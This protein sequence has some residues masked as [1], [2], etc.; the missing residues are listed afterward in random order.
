MFNLRPLIFTLLLTVLFAGWLLL[1]RDSPATASAT[2]KSL[3]AQDQALMEQMERYRARLLHDHDIDYHILTMRQGANLSLQA[4]IAFKR[5]N[6]G[7]TSREG[8]GVLLLLD[9]YSNS[10]VMEISPGLDTVFMDDFV[11]YI[12]QQMPPFL[13]EGQTEQGIFDATE[14]IVLRAKNAK[15]QLDFERE[16]WALSRSEP[17][18]SALAN[19][20]MRNR[21]P[22]IR[23][24][25]SERRTTKLPEIVLARYLRAMVSGYRYPIIEYYSVT[26][27]EVLYSWNESRRQLRQLAATLRQLEPGPYGLAVIGQ[28]DSGPYSQLTALR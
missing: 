9:E 5:L 16:P 25:S 2:Q 19:N 10:A 1:L 15:L 17:R 22:R 8:R 14:M 21:M 7:R 12:E 11:A 6:V 20:P 13:R 23:S 27:Q 3:K 28:E 26:I 18:P 24:R 4:K